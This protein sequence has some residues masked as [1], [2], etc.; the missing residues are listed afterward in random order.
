MA[1]FLDPQRKKYVELQ[2]FHGYTKSA[3][4]REIWPS[5]KNPPGKFWSLDKSPAVIEYTEQCI[6]EEMKDYDRLLKR[7]KTA[8]LTVIT[9]PEH[10]NFVGTLQL[11]AKLSGRLDLADNVKPQANIDITI[12]YE[13]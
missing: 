7:A 9:N 10:K 12:K 11:V 5:T 2:V 8:I 1:K 4:V 3:A 13:E 6:K